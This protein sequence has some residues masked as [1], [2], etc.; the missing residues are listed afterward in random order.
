MEP[1]NSQENEQNKSKY[2]NLINSKEPEI[3][4]EWRKE[5][6]NLKQKLIKSD[7]Y[8]FNLDNNN[9]TNITELKYIA[10][11]DISAIKHN[12]NI[13]VSALVVCD[14]NLKIV[15]EDYNLVKMDEPYIPGFL[16]FREVKH[17]VNLIND[18]KNNHPEFIPQVILV[19]GNGILHTKG[20][21]LASHLG[22][23]I[24]IPTIG[25]SKNVFNVDG[26]S[27]NKVKEMA[28][29]FLNKGGDH[30]PLIGDSGEQYGWAFRSNDE[31]TNPMIISLGHKISNETALKIVKLCTIHRIPQ[32]IRFS[33]KISRRLIAEYENFIN[34]NPGK[35]WDLKQ[36]LNENYAALHNDL[37]D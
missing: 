31:S 6:D 11:M 37:N 27:K 18:L 14:R 20:F 25:C 29:K 4:E 1:S 23:L 24:D 3:L 7:F 26:I 9:N 34:K 30:Y 2:N 22:V 33:D 28:K 17:L 13:A 8:N 19:D 21:G 10:G 35:E 32:P 5:Q 15:Y 16:A 36:Y 12:P